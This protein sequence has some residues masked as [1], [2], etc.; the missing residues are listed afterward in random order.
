MTHAPHTPIDPAL[1]ARWKKIPVAVAVDLLSPAYQIDPAIRP[2]C[3][4]GHQPLLFGRALTA[5]C[6]PPD[7]GSVLQALRFMQAGDV[8]VID[9]QGDRVT[10]LIGDVLGGYLVKIGAAGI[11]CEGA[12]RDV[13]TLA[14]FQTLPVFTRHV[15]PRGPKGAATKVVNDPVTIGGCSVRAGDLIIG[16]DDGLIAIPVAALAEGIERCE[17]KLRLEEAWNKRVQSGEPI[18]TIF[19]LG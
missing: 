6:T 13:G 8:L 4:P 11:V 14:K 2:I 10:A 17:E 9:G 15:T 12:V 7:F 18:E 3:P 16:D 1:L 5:R 19:N